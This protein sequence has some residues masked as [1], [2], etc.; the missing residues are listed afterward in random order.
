MLT[1]TIADTK[2]KAAAIA[3]ARQLTEFKWTPRKDIK[4]YTKKTGV[5]TFPANVEVKGVIYSSPEPIDKF[6]D[7]NVSVETFLSALG[8]PDSVLYEKD[9][10]GANNSWPYYGIVCN[11]FIRYAFGIDKRYSTKRWPTLPGMNHIAEP[12]FFKPEDIELCD[13]LY[14]Y[15]KTGRKHVA[16]IT[17]LL[18]NEDGVIEQIEVS[19]GTRPTC[20]RRQFTVEEFYKK[21]AEFGLWRYQFV[22]DVPELD[23]AADALLN[24]GIPKALPPIAVDYGNKSNYALGEETVISVFLEGE[25]TVEILRNGEIIETVPVTQNQKI[26]RTFDVG[27]YTARLANTNCFTEFYVV[28]HYINY[29]VSNGDLIV[30]ASTSD[31]DSKLYYLDFR[32]AGTLCAPLAKVEELTEQEKQSGEFSRK[33]PAD[34][35]NFKVVF[36]NPFGIWTHKMLEL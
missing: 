4:T 24:K 30:K 20:I 12:G 6:F 15:N 27:K 16:M 19:E 1:S 18:K 17:D 21:F 26:A 3:R 7:E 36:K 11:G 9:L 31:P 35:K 34:A 25:N 5:T 33:I 13:V 8:N 29:S 10:D 22:D 2:G 14:G 23:L 32:E 28:Q